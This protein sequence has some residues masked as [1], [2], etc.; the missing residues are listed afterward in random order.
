LIYERKGI[1]INMTDLQMNLL[2]NALDFLEEAV[3]RLLRNSE[4]PSKHVKYAI[5]HLSSGLE[6]L[7]KY[8]VMIKD[9]TG[10]KA[11]VKPNQSV[12]I[13]KEKFRLGKL[14]TIGL[15]K[16]QN[17][18]INNLN[19]SMSD[20]H[21]EVIERL[22][23]ERDTIEHLDGQLNWNSTLNLLLSAWSF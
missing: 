8:A 6:L 15:Q 9:R 23:T 20:E 12:D 5:I 3:D 4:T 21:L 13:A 19:V 14:E 17:L 10:W 18:L 22:K 16:A 11:I 7:F 2:E 1:V